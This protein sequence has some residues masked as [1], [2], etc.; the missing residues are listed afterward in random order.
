MNVLVSDYMTLEDIAR[1]KGVQLKTLKQWVRNHPNRPVCERI[2]NRIL[3]CRL[4][5][6]ESY[7][8]REV[9]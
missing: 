6:F 1:V 3:V 9:K 5:S 7:Q 4:S 2:G 8:K